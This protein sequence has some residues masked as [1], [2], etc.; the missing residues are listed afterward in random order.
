MEPTIL[1]E[2]NEHVLTLTLNRPEKLNCI[3]WA[4]MGELETVVSTA[5]TEES[6]RLVILRGAGER[7]FSTGGDLKEFPTLSPADT[8]RWI[9]T[10]QR[11]FNRIE[12]LATCTVAVLDGYAFGGGL[13]LA[14]A[15]DLRIATPQTVLCTPELQHGWPP[16]WGAL[17]RLSRIV[18]ESKAK[19]L[20]LLCDRIQADEALRIGLVNRIVDR[21]EI[22]EYLAGLG[23]QMAGVDPNLIAYVKAALSEGK[24]ASGPAALES[25]VLATLYA[26]GRD[27]S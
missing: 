15:C 18:G 14:I 22:E 25:D 7:A 12:S 17:T 24:S 2:R 21:D 6:F 13:E 9:R 26:R 1:Y 23:E 19:E 8:A 4:M 27:G 20:V 11:L 3:N 5:E 10:G 16:G